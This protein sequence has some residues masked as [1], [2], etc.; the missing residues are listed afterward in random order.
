MIRSQ[1]RAFQSC[2]R[3]LFLEALEQRRVFALIVD[4]VS[5]ISDGNMSPG[6]V[7]LREALAVANA[8]PGL[9]TIEFSP[10]LSGAT[11]AT[12]G[13]PYVVNDDVIIVGLGA[14]SLT[15]SGGGASRVFQV[16]SAKSLELSKITVADGTVNGSG[17][18]V[19]TSGTLTLRDVYM[20]NNVSLGV[21]SGGAISAS[22]QLFVFDSRFEGNRA[23]LGGAIWSSGSSSIERSVFVNNSANSGG[24]Y[25]PG[26]I[27]VHLVTDSTFRGNFS[28]QFE[29]GALTNGAALTIRR[30]LFEEN[31]VSN[32]FGAGIFN[33][34][35]LTVEDSTFR[36]NI[37]TGFGGSIA[38]GG[39]LANEGVAI[40]R[41]STFVEN[42][43][44][45][46]GGLFNGARF[47]RPGLLTV[48][49]STIS[50]NRATG[51][52]SGGIGIN[53]FSNGVTVN[54]STIAF[55]R[56]DSMGGV[57]GSFRLTNSILAGNRRLDGSLADF[58]GI[59]VALVN[60]AWFN[61]VISDP[62]SLNFINNGV[63]G[64]QLAVDALLAPLA[65]NGGPTLTHA[66]PANSPAVNR[67]NNALA[68]ATDQRGV[69]RPVG[70]FADVGAYESP[71]LPNS[72]PIA[73]DDNGSMN[74][75]E[76]LT[77]DVL[78]NDSD[79][80][81]DTLAITAVS[82]PSA[83]I[84]QANAEGTITYT[85]NPN[86]FGLDSF[87][88]TISDG[89][90][91]TAT[92]VVRI[93]VLPVNDPPLAIDDAVELD[94]DTSA[95][96]IVLGNDY[97]VDGDALTVS[98]F[99][100]GSHGSVEAV[101]SN[102]LIY[103]PS[104]NYFGIDEFQY[105]ISDGAGGTATAKVLLVVASVNDAPVAVDDSASTFINN[106][107]SVDLL[108]NDSDLDS[109]GL[110]IVSLSTPAH[111][112]V[113]IDFGGTVLYTPE[114]GFSGVD[115]FVYSI[116]DTE[117]AI[118]QAT[119]TIT[120][121][122]NT[123]PVITQLSSSHSSASIN[124]VV[125]IQGAFTDNGG[126]TE[127]HTVLVDW[128]DGSPLELLVDVN[129][130]TDRFKG[131]H[132]YP[133]GGVYNITVRVVD[134]GGLSSPSA[135]TTAYVAGTRIVGTTLYIVG[136]DVD[137]RV[138]INP[139]QQSG[140]MVHASFF[141]NGKPL[142]I[143]QP[144]SLVIAYLD[145]GDDRLSFEG[146]LATPAMVYA[147]TGNDR[148]DGSNGASTLDGGPGDDLIR[149]G[150]GKDTLLGGS[151]NDELNGGDG[152]DILRGGDDDDTLDGGAD[153]DVILGE[154][155]NDSL[156]GGTGRDLLIGGL[157]VD[158]L[159]GDSDQDILVGNSTV[160]D[161]NDA[162]LVSILL[163][164]TSSRS[165]SARM[166]NLLGTGSGPRLNGHFFLNSQ[167]IVDDLAAD[168]IEGS[169]SDDWIIS[170]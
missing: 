45:N 108:A 115:T 31:R 105:V 143:N 73:Q 16:N 37:N 9:E 4:N 170:L 89:Q 114:A 160:H 147:G 7:S 84:A 87:T 111:G 146:N 14:E 38:E 86:F 33:T 91:H 2:K 158:R 13:V 23:S 167:S 26:G 168:R 24:A 125:S 83:G 97:D 49:N 42:E 137:D 159:R 95:T 134:S 19:L 34:G 74:E 136:T 142:I 60:A 62:N 85:P 102:T 53:A 40:V 52:G 144:V 88:Y 131:Q 80:E 10:A 121:I 162:A 54:N 66:L 44:R 165:R 152:D 39:G 169:S 82:I 8:T 104:S 41:R 77:I 29:G 25:V 65:D 163:E 79:P 47:N 119:V 118:S 156:R 166:A 99:T 151:G 148:I 21:S 12:G 59:S 123:P 75:D 28:T 1:S 117:G 155:G 96:V 113:A 20:R 112:V 15:I 5:S 6:N 145:G 69:A 55:N 61:N 157:G 57:D 98:S 122:E 124:R 101:G 81:N 35:D 51:L 92:A 110:E 48:E 78:G 127:T 93:Q 72:A 107:V 67:G 106:S 154:K 138:T 32:T 116:R 132:T 126:P 129:Q 140:L 153:H 149:G 135:S 11:I 30:S 58:G 94:E 46:G 90:G 103:T 130:A 70:P 164:W 36:R 128:G 161:H 109:S 3:R 68:P 17:G 141:F 22:S 56:G 120:V 50:N 64:N 133:S 139:Y 18:A 100:Q 150:R 63:N 43:A 27:G 71:F 76:S